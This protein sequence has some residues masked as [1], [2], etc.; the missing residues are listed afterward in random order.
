LDRSRLTANGAIEASLVV[1]NVGS[2]AADEVVQL[3]VRA[4]DPRHPR[5]RQDLRGIERVSLA[6]GESRRITFAIRAAADLLRYD[7]TVGD[8]VVDPGRYEVRVGASSS[9]IRQ[10]ASFT[11]DKA[12]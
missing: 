6:A 1:K 3:Y 12:S 11:V 7:T 5:A 4:L 2:R 8:Y 9:D 10:R